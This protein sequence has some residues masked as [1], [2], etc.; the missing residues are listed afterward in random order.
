MRFSNL[1]IPDPQRTLPRSLAKN[2]N[3][4]GLEEPQVFKN[5]G[6][7][8]PFSFQKPLEGGQRFAAYMMLDALRV[9]ACNRRRNTER[10]EK[11]DNRFMAR[12]AFAASL[13]PVSVR[14]IER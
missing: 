13:R 14:N 4:R 8:F 9:S 3:S 11:S 12:L 7:L 10:L 1:G 2:P 6:L 5:R